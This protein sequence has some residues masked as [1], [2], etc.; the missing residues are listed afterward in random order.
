MKT[1]NEIATIFTRLDGHPEDSR[2]QL[3]KALRN[4]SQRHYFPPDAQEGKA[5]LYNEE[6]IVALRLVYVTTAFGVDRMEVDA[7]NRWLRSPGNRKVKGKGNG[8]FG[9]NRIRESIERA[10]SGETFRF[11][12]VMNA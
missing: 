12:I 11:H 4:I 3:D 5:F 10:N 1:L 7:F 8:Q 2:Q 6:S 9:V